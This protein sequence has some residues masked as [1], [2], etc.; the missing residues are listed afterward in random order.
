MHFN[1]GGCI[2][3][4]L[5]GISRVGSL[6]EGINTAYVLRQ[7]ITDALASCTSYGEFYEKLSGNRELMEKY[8]DEARE[9]S[10]LKEEV[11]QP[12]LDSFIFKRTVGSRF[13]MTE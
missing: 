9:Y 6:D 7:T 4:M 11:L 12:V 8:R 13:M 2:E 5:A 10:F 3:T 1:G